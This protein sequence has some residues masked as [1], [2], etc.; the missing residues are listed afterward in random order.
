MV[1]AYMLDHVSGLLILR[2]K[3]L[4]FQ[5]CLLKNKFYF[6]LENQSIAKN[7]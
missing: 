6:A 7:Y 2:L 4:I 5:K 1:S 3:K